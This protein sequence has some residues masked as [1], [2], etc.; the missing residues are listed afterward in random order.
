MATRRLEKVSRAIRTAVSEV[1][2]NHLS[3]PRI[4]GLVTVT[5]VEPTPDL[6]TAKVFLSILGVNEQQQEL[7]LKGIKHAHGY[8]Q[9][10]LAGQLTMK[11]CP[12]LRFYL[13]DSLK[14][15]F[16]ITQLLDQV[17]AEQKAQAAKLEQSEVREGKDER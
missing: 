11:T 6:R 1:I 8:V 13:D 15:S 16:A 3:D 17:T 14:K 10:Y 7:S 12:S 5:R 9:S 2:Q 4:Q